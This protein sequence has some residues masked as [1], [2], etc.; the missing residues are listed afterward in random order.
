MTSPLLGV[1]G[2]PGIKAPGLDE[3]RAALADP[4]TPIDECGGCTPMIETVHLA[5]ALTVADRLA[6]ENARLREAH[7]QA[8]KDN[9]SLRCSVDILDQ[10]VAGLKVQRDEARAEAVSIN[11]LARALSDEIDAR[12]DEESV[13]G[14]WEVRDGR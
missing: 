2:R 8:V 7:I 4:H 10:T 6:A 12:D 3:A 13:N 5:T 1:H 14:T 9:I 11:Q